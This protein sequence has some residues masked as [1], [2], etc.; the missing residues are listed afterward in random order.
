MLRFLTAL[1]AL[2]LTLSPVHASLVYS[3]TD[4]GT[5]GGDSSYGL[6]IND[7]GHGVGW[8]TI[9]AGGASVRPFIWTP[10]GGMQGLGSSSA[11]IATDINNN[12]HVVGQSGSR[13]FRWTESTGLVLIDS[14]VGIANGLNDNNEVIGWRRLAGADRTLYWSATNAITNPYP[15][16]NSQGRAINNLGQYVGTTA[17]G[18]LG[19]FAASTA[20][21]RTSLGTFIPTDINDSRMIVGSVGDMAH[22]LDFDL[23]VL[24]PL[25]KLNPTDTFSRALGINEAGTIVGVSQGTGA[26]IYDSNLG[27]LQDLTSLLHSDFAGWTILAAEDINNKNQIIGVGTFGGQQRAVILTVVP[28]PS[29]LLLLALPAATVS[30][31]RRRECTRRVTC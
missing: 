6:A 4:L 10:G 26:F 28:E 30:L 2:M 14:A 20:V 17:G 27:G 13:P 18:T 16:T 7:L 23:G 9:P 11:G 31:R 19:Y 3:L 8:S 29:S 1:L 12:G 15:V 22:L 5:L 25:G 21:A 24:T